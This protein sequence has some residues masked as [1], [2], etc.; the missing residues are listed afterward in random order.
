MKLYAIKT[1][2]NHTYWFEKSA[3][4]SWC[5]FFSETTHRVP[6]TEARK[7]YEAI[8]YKCI[9]LECKEIIEVCMNCR[10]F[11]DCI[12]FDPTL[13]CPHWEKGELIEPQEK[14]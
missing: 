8:G 11:W 7:A 6:L 10:K 12:L 3:F 9:E 4:E 5:S 14:K 2:A 13:R 1:P